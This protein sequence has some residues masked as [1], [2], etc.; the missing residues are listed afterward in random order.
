M[1]Q[2]TKKRFIAWLMPREGDD[3]KYPLE[4]YSR[5]LGVLFDGLIGVALL[6]AIAVLHFTA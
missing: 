5:S 6:A 1:Y 3:I 2:N 4:D